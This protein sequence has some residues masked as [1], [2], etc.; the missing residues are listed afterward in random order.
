M[1]EPQTH[2][3]FEPSDWFA[4]VIIPLYLPKTLTWS[5]PPDLKESVKTG[6]RVEVQVGKQKRYAGIVIRLHQTA[7]VGFS[8]KPI[9]QVLDEHPIVTEEQLKLWTWIAQ[10][11]MCSEGEVMLAAL[12]T[13]LKLSSETILQ[14]NE[15]HGI[16]PSELSDREYVVAEA[17]EVKQELKMG[18]VQKLLDTPHVMPVV[19][20]LI[21]KRICT[22]W[23]TMQDKYKEKTEI[24]IRLNPI[25][26]NEAE[27]ETLVNEWKKAPRQLDLLLAYLHFSRTEG[28]VTRSGLLKK[29]NVTSA[30]LDGLIRKNILEQEVRSIDRLPVLPK[31]IDLNFT[32]SPGQQKALDEVRSAFDKHTVCLLHG[33]TG[34]GKTQ[35]Y[36]EIIAEEIRKGKQCLF[37][38]PEIALTTQIIRKLRQHLGGFAA[39]YHSKF[40]PN[41]RVELWNK[42]RNGEVQVVLG[43]R[44]A[45]FLPFKDLSLVVVDEEHDPS[46]KQQE[47]PP[48]YHAR[49]AAIY[50]AVQVGAKVLLGS[51][52]PSVESYYNA[53]Q[54]KYGLV[55]IPERFGDVELPA[56]ELVD[57]KSIPPKERK[58]MIITP[59]LLQAIQDTLKGGKQIIVFQNRRGYTPYQVCGTCGWIPKCQQCDVSLTYHKSTHRLQCHYCGT[60]YPLVKTCAQCGHQNF[61]QRSFGTEQLQ[62]ALENLLPDVTVARMDTDSVRGKHSHDNLIKQF[63]EQKIDIL[64]GT[65]MVVKGL[66]FDHV[67]L[68]G[69][70]DADGILHFADFRV[71]E[72][73]FQLIEQ[74]SG[75]AGRKGQTGRVIIQLNDTQH[76][77]L[78][79]L[80]AHDYKSFYNN[81]IKS[82]KEFFYPPFSR[83]ILLQAK[84]KDKPTCHR[85]IEFL[86]SYLNRKYSGHINGP[87]EP[88]ISRV[89]NLYIMECLLK[90]PPNNQFLAQCKSY[91]R[92]AVTEMLSIEEFKSVW[93]SADVD[94]L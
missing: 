83:L 72:R 16:D 56:I 59:V 94:T 86:V 29:A 48:R 81:E 33:V 93:I 78:P 23:E 60:S 9:I 77:L 26:N 37:L 69:I 52:T 89:R 3:L 74:V 70:P 92:S 42:V 91:I 34:S 39:V 79:L 65:Q 1:N 35:L 30:V 2:S 71:N 82:R 51:A 10:Y 44:S 6:C 15:G 84:H 87:S 85:A 47:P 12:P 62:E 68:V 7:P 8:P 20:R 17:L 31:Q 24:F 80:M 14:F 54:N 25:Y 13:H 75:R 36:L 49:D 5:V 38:L 90:L 40:N 21:E 67:G 50:F 55:E 27:L 66:D 45:L 61:L 46:Y 28:E 64:A 57:M 19:K 32:L 11:Y 73:A 53:Q 88:A 43:S 4:D 58:G 22:A 18:E 76:P 41:E 63:E